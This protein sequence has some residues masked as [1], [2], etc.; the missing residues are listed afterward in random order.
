MSYTH[1]NDI[2]VIRDVSN[3]RDLEAQTDK[4]PG[5]TVTAVEAD[6]PVLGRRKTTGSLG[7]II[8]AEATAEALAQDA[9]D[10]AL[11]KIGN[12]L[13]K[14]HSASV[15]TRYALYILPV[16]LILAIPLILSLT[17]SRAETWR[18]GGVRLAGVFIWVEICWFALWFCKLVAQA[19]PIIF[20]AICGLI[21]TGIRKYSLVL[22]ALE[23]PLS[24]F[25]WSIVSYTTTNVIC[26]FDQSAEDRARGVCGVNSWMHTMRQVWKAGIIVAAIFLIQKTIMQLISINYH[27][28]QY[29]HKIRE[30]KK[31]IRL[32]DLLYDASRR[33]FP[34]W[35]RDFAEED[36]TIQS[37]TLTG[38]R[39]QLNKAGM[40]K[41]GAEVIDNMHRVR[42]KVTAAF[43]AMASDVTG[44]KL[45]STTNA[46]SIVLK[47]LE[48]EHSSKALA[49]RIWL[50]FTAA[51]KDALYLQDIVEVLGKDRLEDA[52]EIFHVLD[53]DDNGDVSLEE[54]EVL[55]ISA[56][57]ER[58]D[59]A[60]SMQD[61][62]QAIA[63]L[64]K[65]LSA[66]VVVAIAFIYA[67][68]FSPQFASKTS[69]LW[70]SFTGLAFAIG[71][72]VTEFLSCCIFLFVKHPYDVGDRVTIDK[73]ELIVKH[74]SLMYSV[75][76]RVDN[77]GV[78]QIPHNVANNL[79]I[80]NVSRSR[81]MKERITLNVSAGTKME[82]I[83]ALRGELEKF[84]AHDDNRRD[85]QPDFDIEL[86]SVGDLKHLE[87]RVE[88]KHKSNFANEQLRAHRRNKFM[89][90]L[91]AA[92]RRVP[93][94]PP[95]GSGPALG[96]PSNP[97]YS[98]AVSD[99][100]AVAARAAKAEKTEGTRLFPSGTSFAELVPAT[101]GGGF[102][103]PAQAMFP[104][105]KQRNAH[106]HDDVSGRRASMW[107]EKRQ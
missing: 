68:F 81:I 60:T 99:S 76:Q 17:G 8:S 44:Q 4:K 15:I 54:M 64:D 10:D 37:S 92:I 72:T 25:F 67:T 5:V 45:F 42:D 41:A 32:L 94:E 53:R 23:I 31:L 63:V 48:N 3:E 39:T 88:I 89:V 22:K 19:T 66:V 84:V 11:T 75:F 27:R 7:G 30:S 96:D 104:G 79:W 47:A 12:F 34:E 6:R 59:R 78:L 1:S 61:I 97:A 65:M 56:G 21:S 95:G 86:I 62:S 24:L 14:I 71:G 28:K 107:D 57:T 9:D 73:Q 46:H 13:H 35:G 55:I 29:D 91:L 33:M 98:V 26:V 43:G 77:D 52:E 103:S 87:L 49:R 20:Q 2:T 38:V 93:I 74:I 85:F 70:T 80:E 82:E 83:L 106:K 58:K 36:A 69:Q 90:E 100:E 16:A 50:S 40:G 102:L 101:V 18:A 51:G 105:L